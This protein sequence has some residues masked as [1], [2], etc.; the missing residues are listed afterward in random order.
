MKLYL[1]RH[2]E[3]VPPAENP[4]QPLSETGRADVERMAA[5]LAAS[6]P[7]VARVFHSTKARARETAVLLAG[8]LAPGVVPEEAAGLAPNDATDTLADRVAG[9]AGGGGAGD[10]MVVGHLPF[11]P[12][13]VSRLTMGGEFSAGVLFT[14][15]TVACLESLT[16]P[17]WT[18]AWIMRPELLEE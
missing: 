11:M 15:A 10:V 9:W 12:R 18:L 1:V 5:F 6:C 8:V 14:P 3:A 4:Q 2:G 16:E 13:M 17:R 7:P